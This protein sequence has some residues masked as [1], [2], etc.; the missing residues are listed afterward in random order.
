MSTESTASVRFR[1]LGMPAGNDTPAPRRNPILMLH[2]IPPPAHRGNV[3]VGPEALAVWSCELVRNGGDDR[4]ARR[5]GVHT[6]P[7]HRLGLQ[8]GLARVRLRRLSSKTCGGQGRNRT[9]A[10]LFRGRAPPTELLGRPQACV[11]PASASAVAF[12]TS[13][14][15][16]LP[17]ASM[18]TMVRKSF[19]RRCHMAS[20]TPNSS[21]CTPS[22]FSTAWA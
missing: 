7:G 14:C 17:C 15:R 8:K 16:L 20:G 4:G 12:S 11:N 13:A 5:G 19:T 10:S 18:V 21:R 6:G 3:G 2:I 1:V 22:T 9:D